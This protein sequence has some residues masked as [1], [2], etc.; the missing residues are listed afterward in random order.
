[1]CQCLVPKN[2]TRAA[3]KAT[4]E[5]G[6]SLIELLLVVVIIG[7]VASIAVPNYIRG[8]SAAEK[9]GAVSLLRTISSAQTTFYT[10]RGRY[11]RLDEL[12]STGTYFGTVE[13]PRILKGMYRFEMTPLVPTD[14]EI[15]NEYTISAI[16]DLGDIAQYDLTQSGRIVQVT[17]VGSPNDF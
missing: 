10:A 15:K 7:I 12:A 8:R 13:S 11:A 2:V 17:P 4:G 16:R 6:F 9:A 14:D 5:A 1:M 3:S